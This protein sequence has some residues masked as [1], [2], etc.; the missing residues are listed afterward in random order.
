[1]RS[2][3]QSCQNVGR[4]LDMKNL[5]ALLVLRVYHLSL[6]SHRV[7][8]SRVLPARA[9]GAAFAGVE[10]HVAPRAPVIIFGVVS[11]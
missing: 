5:G 7:V 4:N 2:H 9:S 11:F 1:M 3:T 8:L 10:I 6:E